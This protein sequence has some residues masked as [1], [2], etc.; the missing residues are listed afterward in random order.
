MAI[1]TFLLVLHIF[2]MSDRNKNSPHRDSRFVAGI[3]AALRYREREYPCEAYNLSRS[4]VLLRGNF[5]LPESIAVEFTL[6]HPHGDIVI[7]LRG[8]VVRAYEEEGSE[9]EAQ[10]HQ[11]NN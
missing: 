5:P 8:R 11:I 7:D 6:R 3:P 9:V 1:V 10:P 2:D 4:G